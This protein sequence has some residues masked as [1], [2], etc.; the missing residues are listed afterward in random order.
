LL[1]KILAE[2]DSVGSCVFLLQQEVAQRVCAVPGT[3]KFAPLSILLQN[4]FQTRLHFR[5]PASSFSPPPRVE[6]ALISLKKR[7][8]PLHF[9]PN[10]ETFAKFLKGAFHS[11]RKKLSNNLKALKISPSQIREA[12]LACGIDEK[13]RPEQV[14]ISQFYALFATLFD[15]PSNPE[16]LV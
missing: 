2:K 5:V 12:Y 13:L 6:S 10:Q 7:H 1:F 11:R 4:E 15:N 3:K 8:Q 9:V 16:D 14:S